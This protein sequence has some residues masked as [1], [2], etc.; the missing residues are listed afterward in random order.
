MSAQNSKRECNAH[1]PETGHGRRGWPR[2]FAPGSSCYYHSYVVVELPPQTEK[3]L[4]VLA[5]EQGRDAV[6]I[7]A[8]ALRYYFESLAISDVDPAAVG[9]G[10]IQLVR[11]L[12]ALTAWNA[13]DT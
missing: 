12:P 11:E 5:A 3:Q 7:L 6:A 13:L 9:Q 4:Q 2:R 10:Q 8:D 1:A